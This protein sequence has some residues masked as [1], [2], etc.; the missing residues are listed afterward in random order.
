MT[1]SLN[2][3]QGNVATPEQKLAAFEKIIL[4]VKNGDWDAKELLYKEFTPLLKSLS[5]KRAADTEQYNQ[6]IEAG[7]AG[8][9]KAAKKYKHKI[10][11]EKFRIFALDFIENEMEKTIKGNKGLFARFF[12]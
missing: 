11:P 10:H 2:L 5:E 6:L 1:I 9:V 12:K 8:L 4:A 7:K 3:N